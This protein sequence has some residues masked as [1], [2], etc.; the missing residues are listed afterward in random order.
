[1]DKK[2]RREI[3]QDARISFYI[4]TSRVYAESDVPTTQTML[5]HSHGNVC[6]EIVAR[7]KETPLSP[8]IFSFLLLFLVSSVQVLLLTL[9]WFASL[10]NFHRECA[11]RLP[12]NVHSYK[13]L[14]PCQ[15][16]K[17]EGQLAWRSPV[18]HFALTHRVASCLL[19]SPG[20][21]EHGGQNVCSP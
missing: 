5:R 6:A 13:A 8:R 12:E 14:A 17:V 21:V 18:R 15:S 7:N 4:A 9:V 20:L 19:P 1:M 3:K 2:A 10:P 11:E 16:E